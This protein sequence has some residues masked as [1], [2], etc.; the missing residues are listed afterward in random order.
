MSRFMVGCRW[1]RAWVTL[2]LPAGA[3]EGS[4]EQ[5]AIELGGGQLALG[6]GPGLAG[7]E[8][9]YLHALAWASEVS[10]VPDLAEPAVLG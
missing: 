2:M 1:L 6:C 10:G 7:V 4:D 3:H 9:C 5:F 8:K